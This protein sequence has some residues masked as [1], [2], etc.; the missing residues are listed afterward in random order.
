MGKT[1]MERSIDFK[2]KLQLPGELW[3]SYEN[4]EIPMGK[5]LLNCPIGISEISN[6]IWN[7]H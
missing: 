1:P 5:V 2:G 6:E 3:G 4:S 7:S